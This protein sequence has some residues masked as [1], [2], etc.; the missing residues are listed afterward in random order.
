MFKSVCMFRWAVVV[1]K[2]VVG[3]HLATEGGPVPH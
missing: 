2:L 3:R 1:G